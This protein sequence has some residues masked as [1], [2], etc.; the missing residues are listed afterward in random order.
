MSRTCSPIVSTGARR[1][2]AR[3]RMTAAR[4]Q[5]VSAGMTAVAS[6]RAVRRVAFHNANHVGRVWFVFD[7]VPRLPSI[8]PAMRRFCRSHC[9]RLVGHG[10]AGGA[11]GCAS[12]RLQRVGDQHERA[13]VVVAHEDVV[14]LQ[15]HR[16]LRSCF[17][18]PMRFAA[19]SPTP[20]R[21]MRRP[22]TLITAPGNNPSPTEPTGSATTSTAAAH[23]TPPS[24]LAHLPGVLVRTR[25][26]AM[27]V[28][29]GAQSALEGALGV[30]KP[31]AVAGRSRVA[32]A[33]EQA[34]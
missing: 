19:T 28:G 14:G 13:G 34:I 29:S 32:P 31:A 12:G 1:V 2:I 3:G 23:R 33:S 6:S 11:A 21:W 15:E 7:R 24:T 18:C 30:D 4:T 22:P 20:A 27:R 9:G 17:S 10:G 26:R 5:F 16:V 25:P 8:A